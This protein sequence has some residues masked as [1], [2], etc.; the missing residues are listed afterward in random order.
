MI[1]LTNDTAL[2]TA[3][4][5][6]S[7]RDLSAARGHLSLVHDLDDYLGDDVVIDGLARVLIALAHYSTSGALTPAQRDQ[8]HDRIA[9]LKTVD[10]LRALARDAGDRVIAQAA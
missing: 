8:A 7:D 2:A 9:D 3:Y 5:T 6:L 10:I 1:K 4:A